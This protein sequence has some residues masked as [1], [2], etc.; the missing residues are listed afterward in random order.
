MRMIILTAMCLFAS[1]CCVNHV[2]Q[3]ASPHYDYFQFI[4]IDASRTPTCPS[5]E[6]RDTDLIV[7]AVELWNYIFGYDYKHLGVCMEEIRNNLV[8]P[9]TWAQI[10]SDIDHGV[11]PRLDL[12]DLTEVPSGQGPYVKV[13]NGY[14]ID[15]FPH[16]NTDYILAL[17]PRG[18]SFT[19]GLPAGTRFCVLPR[20]YPRPLG[21][22]LKGAILGIILTP[23]SPIICPIMAIRSL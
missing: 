1:G 5:S 11:Y 9:K 7:S 17:I 6:P 8:A 16:G 2:W 4:G 22:R 3:K 18:V 19:E 23:I 13:W 20:K 10:G 14:T 21:E 15:M 12:K